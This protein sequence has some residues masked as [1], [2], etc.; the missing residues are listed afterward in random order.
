LAAG[1]AHTYRNVQCACHSCNQ[2]KGA[3]V[4]GQLRLF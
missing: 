2:A 3:K 1:G 4:V